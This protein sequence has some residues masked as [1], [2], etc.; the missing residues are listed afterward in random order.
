MTGALMCSFI[1]SKN[2]VRSR[3]TDTH[4]NTLCE[5]CLVSCLHSSFVCSE[6]RKSFVWQDAGAHVAQRGVNTNMSSR[7]R[8][9]ARA[10]QRCRRSAEGPAVSSL[11]AFQKHR[12]AF[13]SR[14]L[15]IFQS[16]PQTFS[17]SRGP[18]VYENT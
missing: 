14:T 15:C 11:L 18:G 1:R 9:E 16:T 6:L 4:V 13:L 7:R 5:L 2:S 3:V 17:L 8:R 12:F 10:S